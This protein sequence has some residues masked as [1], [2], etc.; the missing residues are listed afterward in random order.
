MSP[1]E[2]LTWFNWTDLAKLFA[3]GPVLSLSYVVGTH[4]VGN[5]Q[6]QKPHAPKP[7]ANAVLKDAIK[8]GAKIPEDKVLV[9]SGVSEDPNA[10]ALPKKTTSTALFAGKKVVIVG[11]PIPFSP[12]CH[13]QQLPGFVKKA[14]DLKKKGVDLVAVIN[15]YDIFVQHAWGKDQKVGDAVLMVSDASVGEGGFLR[16]CGLVKDISAAP[17]PMGGIVSKRFAMVVDDMQV[18]YLGVDD[19]GFEKSSVEAVLGVL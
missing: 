5:F 16:E 14:A 3:V 19:K 15:T 6:Q 8:E 2:L 10:C 9:V 1:P 17:V 18:K 13:L 4:I 7:A 11:I 12:T